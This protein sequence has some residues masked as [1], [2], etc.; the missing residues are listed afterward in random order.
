MLPT[1]VRF[2][3]SIHVPDPLDRLTLRSTRARSV[4]YLQ[5]DIEVLLEVVRCR[6]KLGYLLSVISVS[7]FDSPVTQHIPL[8]EGVAGFK[9]LLVEHY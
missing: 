3:S 7:R 5:F 1:L 6:S 8:F 2:Q 4:R 9:V